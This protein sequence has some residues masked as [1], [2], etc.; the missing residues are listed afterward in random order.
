MTGDQFGWGVN[1]GDRITFSV[2]ARIST[3]FRPPVLALGCEFYSRERD[4][5]E[6]G[7]PGSD[8]PLYHIFDDTDWTFITRTVFAPPN[9]LSNPSTEVNMAQP[10]VE[11]RRA[12]YPQAFKGILEVDDGKVTIFGGTDSPGFESS[13]DAEFQVGIRF[14]GQILKSYAHVHPLRS[15]EHPAI[16]V[17]T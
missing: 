13:P 1:A 9:L 12:S 10:Y 7:G 3:T 5:S 16:V 11:A 6:A 17:L 15:Y 4:L 14:S 2:W 8:P